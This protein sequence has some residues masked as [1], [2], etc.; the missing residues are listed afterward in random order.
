MKR[1]R[2][3]LLGTALVLITLV[4]LGWI[5]GY[6]FSPQA[7]VEDSLRGLYFS[8]AEKI[9]AVPI[10]DRYYYLYATDHQYALHGARKTAGI[11]YVTTGGSTHAE[12]PCKAYTST[13]DI[14]WQWHSGDQIF[15][16]HRN[17]LEI[18]R[19]EVFNENGE[20]EFTIDSWKQD[21]ALT[22][23][24]CK[25]DGNLT[26]PKIYRAYDAQG[27]LVEERIYP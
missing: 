10:A 25:D 26:K 22:G 13:F 8:P 17:I 11:F 21:F 9:D 5:S 3:I 14:D 7:C 2:E 20:H 12:Y 18:Q 4:V 6:Y 23:R 24:K 16:F 1:K 27:N 19:I 15:L